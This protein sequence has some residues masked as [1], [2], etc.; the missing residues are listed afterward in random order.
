M[1]TL[2]MAGSGGVQEDSAWARNHRNQDASPRPRLRGS[3]SFTSAPLPTRTLASRS[4][5]NPVSVSFPASFP[6]IPAPFLPPPGVPL[7]ILPPE[8][9]NLSCG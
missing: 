2:E 4:D 9:V 7:S 8:R 3:A 1:G 5:P 6:Q